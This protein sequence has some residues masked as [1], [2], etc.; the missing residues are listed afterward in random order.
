MNPMFEALKI[1]MREFGLAFKE[2]VFLASYGEY[3]LRAFHTH[4]GE[5]EMD[6][7]GV[8]TRESDAEDIKAFL[9]KV[10]TSL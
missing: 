8:W 2:D 4:A 9:K 5:E 1:L 7:I 6:L 3:E 10:G